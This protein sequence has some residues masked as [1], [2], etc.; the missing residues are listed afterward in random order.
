MTVMVVISKQFNFSLLAKKSNYMLTYLPRDAI[1]WQ[2]GLA[3]RKTLHSW[4][5]RNKKILPPTANI[6]NRY[7]SIF[8]KATNHLFMIG[9]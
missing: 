9:G 5:F 2:R 6:Y 3:A 4:I 1:A 8:N 7:Y